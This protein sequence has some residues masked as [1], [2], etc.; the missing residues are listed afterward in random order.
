MP[1]RGNAL[2]TLRA[3]Q[4][5]GVNICCDDFGTGYSSFSYLQNLA[6]NKI[7][8]DQSFV[9]ALG[10]NPSALRI[11]QAILAMAHSL[12]LEVIA[13]GVET[14]GQYSI[15]KELQCGEMQGFL[16]G[17][18]MP[19]VKVGDIVQGTDA[20]ASAALSAG[21]G[22]IMPLWRDESPRSISAHG[23][24]ACHGCHRQPSLPRS[25]YLGAGIGPAAEERLTWA[26]DR[27][28]RFVSAAT[29][30]PFDTSPKQRPQL[31][32]SP[33]NRLSPSSIP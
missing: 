16:F 25:P 1:D 9:Q 23:D 27:R 19:G 21:W 11:V 3:L 26:S 13:E 14:E 20:D 12:E 18:P 7:K 28:G 24:P 17:K 29:S 33:G 6:F 4:D 5:I 15:L 2:A 8:I 31:Y 32:P 10:I 22:L 30:R